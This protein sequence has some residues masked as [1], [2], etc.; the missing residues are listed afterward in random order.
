MKFN[1]LLL[2]P[3]L[4]ATASLAGCANE[5]ARQVNLNLKY[6]TASSAPATSDANAQAQMAEA[7]TSVD[8]SLNQLSAIQIAKNPGVKM[9][10]PVSAGGLSKQASLNW[11][12][13]VEQAVAQIASAANYHFRVLGTKP[14]IAILV[15]ISA[16]NQALS[17]ILRNVT[18][19]ATPA[20]TIKVYP[21][22]RTIEL[23]Y[24]QK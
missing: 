13:P 5:S 2:I 6:I 18:F 12:G 3:A 7:S 16:S 20:A 10:N 9:Q 17:D 15:N 8:Q 22:T 11:N 21:S 14:S 1:K 4:I 24:N 23:R 19:Q